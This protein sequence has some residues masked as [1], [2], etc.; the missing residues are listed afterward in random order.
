MH[1]GYPMLDD[2]LALGVQRSGERD[3][4]ANGDDSKKQEEMLAAPP[5]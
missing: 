2:L 3:R 5:H 4:H 1:A